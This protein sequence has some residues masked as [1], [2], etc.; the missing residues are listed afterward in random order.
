[1]KANARQRK[2]YIHCLHEDGGL[3]FSQEE[4]EKVAEDYF[5][6]HLGTTTA[7]TL[8]LNWQELGYTLIDLHHLELPFS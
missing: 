1:M 3:V 6:E 4:K 7:R 2:N 5:S 8:S